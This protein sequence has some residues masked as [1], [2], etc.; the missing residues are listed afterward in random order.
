LPHPQPLAFI[1]KDRQ[2]NTTEEKKNFAS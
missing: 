2:K 1:V